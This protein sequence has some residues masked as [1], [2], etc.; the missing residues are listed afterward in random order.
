MICCWNKQIMHAF[1]FRIRNYSSEGSNTQ[2]REV[3]FNII[4]PTLNDFD[5]IQKMAWG[6]CF[7]IYPLHQ[8]NSK[9][10]NAKKMQ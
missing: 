9:W 8:T 5:I 7:I 4:F 2:R 1:L 6:I 10:V 3:G